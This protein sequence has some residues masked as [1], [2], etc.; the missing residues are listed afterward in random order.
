MCIAE[1]SRMFDMV[2]AVEKGEE[3]N[4]FFVEVVDETLKQIFSDDGTKVIYD[5]LEKHSNLKLKEVAN[6][7]EVFSASL[8]RLMVS[9]ARVIEQI[10][11]KNLY[12]RLELKFEEKQGYEFADYILELKGK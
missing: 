5:F 2:N 1:V 10:I 4:E 8:E 9:A 7:P 3:W 12:S 11:L 6:K